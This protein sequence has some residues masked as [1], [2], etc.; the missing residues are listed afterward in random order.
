MKYFN[1]VIFLFLSFFGQNIF[2]DVGRHD[3]SKESWSG[4]KSCLVCH[5]LKNN[6]PK[7]FPSDARI[8]DINKLTAEEQAALDSNSNNLLYIFSSFVF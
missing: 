3:F 1:L 2:A 7:V 8:I 5:D 4:G 6:L